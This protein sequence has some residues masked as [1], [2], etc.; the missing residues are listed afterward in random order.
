MKIC[1]YPGSFDPFTK[2]HMDILLRGA[3]LFD[4]IVVGVL[5]NRDK[6][7][8]FTPEER[9]MWIE[10]CIAAAGLEAHCAVKAFTGM[11]VDFAGENDASAILRGLRSVGDFEYESQIAQANRDMADVD[12]VFLL[13][14]GSY[15][16]VS[17]TVVRDVGMYGRDVSPWVPEAIAAEV[18]ARL[19]EQGEARSAR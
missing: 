8:V 5:Y 3:A 11:T 15:A 6:R 13:T 4:K 7:T 14:D 10:R 9:V 18:G 2:G 19:A 12:T 17:S 16:H 1:I